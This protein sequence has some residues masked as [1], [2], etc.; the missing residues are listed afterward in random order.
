M[1]M[2]EGNNNKK[3]QIQNF[4]CGSCI[5]YSNIRTGIYQPD[6]RLFGTALLDSLR[7]LGRSVPDVH[8]FSNFVICIIFVHICSFSF[9]YFK[10]GLLAKQIADF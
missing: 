1:R 2:M 6:I 10:R 8:K 3:I 7:I 5:F 4:F 9:L